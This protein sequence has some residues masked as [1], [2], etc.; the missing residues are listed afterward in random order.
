MNLGIIIISITLLGSISNW[1]NWHYLNYP[2]VRWLYYLGSAVHELSHAILCVLTGS[3]VMELSI[4]SKQPHVT[5]TKSGIPI[6]GEL[7]ISLAPIFG[8]LFFLYLINKY[9]LG[10]YIKVPNFYDWRSF[11][12]APLNILS[13]INIFNWK[14]CAVILLSFNMGAMVGP[15]WKDLK[16]VWLIIIVLLLFQSPMFDSLGLFAIFLILSNIFIQIILV[17]I[18]AIASRFFIT[19][20]S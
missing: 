16:N 7:L 12:L 18:I 2:V 19:R 3:R 17:L 5:H 15:S 14:G 9:Y 8:G 1:I 11:F 20:Y 6:L 10:D 4:F 13:Q